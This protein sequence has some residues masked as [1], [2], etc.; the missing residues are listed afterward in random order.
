MT[1][2]FRL[3]VT[4]M[5][6]IALGTS[7]GMA[8]R[9]ASMDTDAGAVAVQEIATG[10]NH[11]WGI[12]FLPNGGA[13]VTERAGNV[14]RLSTDGTL[15]EPLGG[16]PEV[17]ARGQGGMLDVALDPDFTDNA[18]VYLSFAEPGE[19][20]ASTAVGRGRLSGN[21][22]ED[23]EVLFRQQPKHSSPRHF[24]GR[25]AFAPDGTLFLTTGDRGQLEPAQDLDDHLGT[26]VRINADGPIPPDNPFVEQAD[27]R[28]AIWSY[29]HRNV[30]AAAFHPQT[31]DLWVA[32]MG[33][34]GGDEINQPQA[35]RNYG[36]P[37]VSW[38]RHYNGTDIPNPPTHPKFADAALHWTPVISPSGMTFYTGDR[39]PEWRGSALTGGLSAQAV[40]RVE[41]DGGDAREAE[42]L[43]LNQRIRE[44]A[45]APDGTIY[46]L[47]D[48]DDGSVWRLVPAD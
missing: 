46:L 14:L 17:Y 3:A 12:A 38:G 7:P 24:G 19:D 5:A 11:P 18:R 4:A 31:G 42:R 37:V 1:P 9:I 39:F 8:Q 29:G 45:Q 40:V 32:E 35:G 26:I 16:V 23:F 47:T 21:G 22:I 10:L 13:L 36:W 25:I 15:S 2:S 43:P 30:E 28:D 6:A 20:G 27:A 41:I 34:Y 33:P 44:V 48:Q